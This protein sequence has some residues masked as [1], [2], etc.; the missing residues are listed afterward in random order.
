MKRTTLAIFAVAAASASLPCCLT[1]DDIPMRLAEETAII[2]WDASTKTQHFIRRAAFSG[3]AKDFGFIL[4]T[5]TEP[6]RIEIANEEAFSVLEWLHRTRGGFKGASGGPPGGVEILQQ[7]L[8][9]DYQ[10]TVLR[11]KDGRSI[12]KW[13]QDNKHQSRPAM[14]PWLDHYAK[15][16]Y[17]F[18][19]FKYQGQR[20][21]TPTR[22]VC[23]SFKTA[24]PFY[25]YK[26]P[27]DTW[28]SG[29]HRR[30]DLFVVSTSRMVGKHVDG[31]KWP[32]VPAWT[33]ALGKDADRFAK[34]ISGDASTIKLPKDL[35]VTRFAN[36][37]KATHY[38]SDLVFEEVAGGR[39]ASIIW[40]APMVGV[41]ALGLFGVRKLRG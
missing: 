10:V 33:E 40:L 8:V 7:K 36:S 23:V 19:A 24:K 27:A 4:P 20:G 35:V 29:H 16:G 15:Q 2:V 34:L 11:A 13:L 32:T 12:T 21:P 25:P 26:M 30:L 1:Y 28:E 9:G 6:N 39:G 22:A 38:G 31:S 37:P 41:G 17:V 5:P 18:S 3:E 14:T